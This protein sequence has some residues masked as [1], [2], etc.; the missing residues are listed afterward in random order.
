MSH[1]LKLGLG[2]GHSPRPPQSGGGGDWLPAGADAYADFIGNHFYADG[3]EKSLADLFLDVDLGAIDANGMAVDTS[4]IG[5]SNRPKASALLLPYFTDH[6]V[7]FQTY[8]NNLSTHFALL[9]NESYG[10]ANHGV[11]V[12]FQQ[13]KVYLT[14]SFTSAF[15]ITTPDFAENWPQLVVKTAVMCGRISG[16]DT[17]WGASAFGGAPGTQTATGF[18]PTWAQAQ[19][20]WSEDFVSVLAGRIQSMTFYP[21]SAKDEDDLQALS[22][23]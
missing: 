1:G 10:S 11:T 6:V 3:A 22:A 7:V 23:A 19:I 18:V 15:E 13:T 9:D 8:G 21:T 4:G 20:G 12:Q 17:V 5:A 14:E 16:S 2:L